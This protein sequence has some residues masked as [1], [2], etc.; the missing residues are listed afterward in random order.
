LSQS[1]VVESYQGGI[2]YREGRS[3]YLPLRRIAQRRAARAGA[4]VE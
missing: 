4:R 2:E 3:L 1:A